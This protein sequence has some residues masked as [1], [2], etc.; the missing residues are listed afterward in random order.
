MLGP[1]ALNSSQA[2]GGETIA[3]QLAGTSVSFNGTLAPIIYTSFAQVA[4]IVPDG[5]EGTSAEVSL[6]S[7]GQT[8][9]PLSIALA[10]SAPGLFTLDSTGRGQAAAINQ[11]G[12]INSAVYPAPDGSMVSLFATGMSRIPPAGID[13]KIAED[14]LAGSL[15]PVTVTLGAERLPP[16]YA[17]TVAGE[18]G[19]MQI[20]IHIPLNV[21]PGAAVPVV[22]SAGGARSQT[23]VTLA[24]GTR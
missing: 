7:Q 23:G 2:N 19:V 4:A 21:P 10:S 12:T 17:E 24:I 6:T 18:N 5:L 20:N 9:P 16:V 14:R 1:A 22:V 15:L 13:G 8:S 3:T 11:D